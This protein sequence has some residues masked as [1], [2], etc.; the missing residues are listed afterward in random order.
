MA[1]CVKFFWEEIRAIEIVAEEVAAELGGEDPLRPLLRELLEH[2]KAGFTYINRFLEALD[3]TVEL[4]E[5]D[6]ANLTDLRAWVERN[7]GNPPALGAGA[8][9]GVGVEWGS[10][11]CG[12][13]DLDPTPR[14]TCAPGQSKG[15][16]YDDR[17]LVAGSNPGGPTR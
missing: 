16:T 11:L 4:Q 13:D 15:R 10:F 3:A 5:P 17:R 2:S 1:A 7:A 8:A 14:T 12:G 6:E 9:T